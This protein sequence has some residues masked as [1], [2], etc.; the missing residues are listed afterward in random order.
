[1]TQTSETDAPLRFDLSRGRIQNADGDEFMLVPLSVLSELCREL[2]EDS[3]TSFGYALGTDIGRRVAQTAGA[4]GDAP[5]AASLH[6]VVAAVGAQLAVAGFGSLGVE[7]WG[8]ALVFTLRDASLSLGGSEA[9][10]RADPLI[11]SLLSG[12]LM[13]AFSRDTNVVALGRVGNLARFVVCSPDVSDLIESW[14]QS[15]LA[16]AE[17]LGRLNNQAGEL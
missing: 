13:R 14:V 6:Q 17:V 15:Q 10:D 3:L 7:L 16:P 12:V 2:P 4:G 11:G 9:V 8:S 1:M 5:H